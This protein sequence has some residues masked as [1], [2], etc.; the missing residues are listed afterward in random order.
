MPL[1]EVI[2]LGTEN[3]AHLLIRIVPATLLTGKVPINVSS[4][5]V[6]ER[7]GKRTKGPF[8]VYSAL[9]GDGR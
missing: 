4:Y 5:R 6:G 7:D 8:G 1:Y 9:D 2:L 3:T